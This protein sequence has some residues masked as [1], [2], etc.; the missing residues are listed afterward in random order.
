MDK[1]L[2]TL[3]AA[4]DKQLQSSLEAAEPE[5]CCVC[6]PHTYAR[7]RGRGRVRGRGRG[8]GRG[9]GR[10]RV[11]VRVEV[12]PQTSC[13]RSASLSRVWHVHRS[14]SSVALYMLTYTLGDQA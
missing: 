8:K 9:K 10:G 5:S 14:R 11:G 4:A 7:G 12:V 6:L 2:S 13:A 1:K 3:D